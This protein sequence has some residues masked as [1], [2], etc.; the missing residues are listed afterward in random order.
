MGQI[1]GHLGTPYGPH[2]APNVIGRLRIGLRCVA[3]PHQRSQNYLLFPRYV[4]PVFTYHGANVLRRLVER[5]ELSYRTTRE[6]NSIIDN[7][8]PGPPPFQCIELDVGNEH[9]EFFCRDA[10]QCIRSLY[11]D[12]EFT[13]GMAFAPERHYTDDERT[14]HVVNEMY[15][16]DLWWS[17]QVRSI[18]YYERE[19]TFRI[20]IRRPL[21]H[22]DRAQQSYPLSSHPVRHNL[23]SSVGKLLTQSTSRL[24]TS[25]RR[26]AENHRVTHRF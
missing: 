6:L 21:N 5:L 12:P 1:L 18:N 25:R 15:T 13:K 14:C 20:G 24:E 19:L 7:N 26:Y 3:R 8:L 22:V 16:G 17:V 23:R 2:F 4:P 11:G 10:L 9:L